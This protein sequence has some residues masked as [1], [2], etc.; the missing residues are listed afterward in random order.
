[1]K[2]CR[3]CYTLKNNGVL[4]YYRLLFFRRTFP[5]LSVHWLSDTNCRSSSVLCESRC[6]LLCWFS[7]PLSGASGS[8]G[9]RPPVRHE[10]G[11]RRPTRLFK[12]RLPSGG[13]DLHFLRGTYTTHEDDRHRDPLSPSLEPKI[14][15]TVAQERGRL[16][17]PVYDPS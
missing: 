5:D 13:G 15:R 10:T 3:L 14:Y 12:D 7:W 4:Y 11:S 8:Q 16:I 17:G 9:R 1:M 6:S 2:S